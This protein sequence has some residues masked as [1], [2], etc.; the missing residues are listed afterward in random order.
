MKIALFT[1]DISALD[2]P[3]PMRELQIVLPANRMLTE[4]V[5]RLEEWARNRVL[6][7]DY[8]ILPRDA[9]IHHADGMD[10]YPGVEGDLGVSWFYTMLFPP[11]ILRRMPIVN[12]HAGPPGPRALKKA[13]ERKDKTIRC[14]WHWVD[15]GVDTGTLI[16]ERTIPLPADW[17][18]A[19]AAIMSTGKS[20]FMEALC[21]LGLN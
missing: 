1:S 9:A 8:Q 11:E 15:E 4:K 20:L 19:R 6:P 16:I 18:S 21:Q 17:H 2:L 3:L 10:A 5:R 13:L 7:W 14:F 12:Y